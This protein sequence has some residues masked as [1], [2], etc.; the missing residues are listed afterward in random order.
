[1]R[2][3]D[4]ENLLLQSEFSVFFSQVNCK[5][6]P[7]PRLNLLKERKKPAVPVRVSNRGLWER[8]RLSKRHKGT[9][10]FFS[11]LGKNCC[12]SHVLSDRTSRSSTSRTVPVHQNRDTCC[13]HKKRRGRSPNHLV[14]LLLFT[15][16]TKVTVRRHTLPDI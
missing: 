8:S 2:K 15:V 3:N 10:S 7:F 5:Q 12:E 13:K 11:Q 14:G 16:C 4:F 6:S 9:L 1:M